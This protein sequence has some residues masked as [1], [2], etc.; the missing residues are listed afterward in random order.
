LKSSSSARRAEFA[1]LAD[2]CTFS[3]TTD[4]EIERD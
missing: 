4:R 2:S 3:L 1:A